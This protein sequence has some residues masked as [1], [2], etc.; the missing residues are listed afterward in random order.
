MNRPLFSVILPTYQRPAELRRVL[1]AWSAQSAEGGDFEIILIDDGSSESTARAIASFR[2][3]RFRL[4]CRRQ[5]NQGPAAAR[6]LAIPLARGQFLLFSGDDIEPAVDLLARH[7]EAHCREDDPRTAILG[8]TSWPENAKLS[9]TMRHIDGPGAEQFSYYWMEDGGE[10]DFRHF[11]TSNISLRRELLDLAPGGFSTEFPAAA[12]E[13]V[14]FGYQLSRFGMRII[15]AQSARAFHHHFYD[16][17]TFFLRQIRCGEMA[18]Y[19]W[20]KRP[21]LGRWLSIAELE[22]LWQTAALSRGRQAGLLSRILRNLERW[23]ARA[24]SLA[25]LYDD[26]HPPPEAMDDYL[27]TLFRYAFLRGLAFGMGRMSERSAAA[28]FL[29]LMPSAAKDFADGLDLQGL[30]PPAEDLRQ[31]LS[32]HT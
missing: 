11:Y 20:K 21:E 31:I 8:H 18:A 1:K 29:T 2:T 9:A 4:R 5:Q 10:Y 3:Q 27:H 13:D 15:Y 19:L 30:S 25:R 22:A 28:A 24:I 23:E 12:F 7:A 32:L 14:D 17:G 16:V 6:N 26:L